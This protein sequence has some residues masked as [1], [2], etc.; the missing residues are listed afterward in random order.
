MIGQRDSTRDQMNCCEKVAAGQKFI[1][2]QH[3]RMTSLYAHLLVTNATALLLCPKIQAK[4]L[5]DKAQKGSV[6]AK[7]KLFCQ[8]F[9]RRPL[10]MNNGNIVTSFVPMVK[11]RTPS[12]P[13]L[14]PPLM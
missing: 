9:C 2:N 8:M 10:N 7:M 1:A 4:P 6:M 11:V 5:V 12:P 3:T 14:A 13:M